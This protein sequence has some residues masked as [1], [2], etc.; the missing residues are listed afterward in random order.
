MF[1]VPGRQYLVV[2]AS[3][4]T[5]K[6]GYRV[7]KWYCGQKLPVTP[8]NPH[9]DFILDLKCN[10]SVIDYMAA[11]PDSTNLGVSFIVPPKAA[12]ET[13]KDVIK[14]GKGDLIKSMWFQPGSSDQNVIQF[15]GENFK[16]DELIAD[17]ECILVSG[18]TRLNS[19]KLG[20]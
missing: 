7:L 20:L 10:K 15:I 5:S 12:L 8:I 14:E 3:T 4:N 17:G 19:D 2:G 13:L 1:F 6:F 9:S 11:H 16:L 18:K